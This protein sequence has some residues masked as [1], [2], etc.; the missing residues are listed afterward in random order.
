M[1]LVSSGDYIKQVL[2]ASAILLQSL[3]LMRMK[4]NGCS[5]LLGTYFFD[6]INDPEPTCSHPISVSEPIGSR[7]Q[8]ICKVG[9]Q[10]GTQ[11]LLRL[12]HAPLEETEF[13]CH[14]QLGRST[15]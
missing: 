8:C 6:R 9:G 13:N 3:W 12:N 2:M 15:N 7:K 11:I 5:N 4:L 1:D 10:L 14:Y